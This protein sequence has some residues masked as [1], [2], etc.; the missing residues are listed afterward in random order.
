[1]VAP[2]LRKRGCEG[3]SVE[4]TVPTSPATGDV[5]TCDG[6]ERLNQPKGA[7]GRSKAKATLQRPSTGKAFAAKN[8]VILA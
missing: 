6:V 1:L 5:R 8:R 7:V 4:T 3:S 2:L